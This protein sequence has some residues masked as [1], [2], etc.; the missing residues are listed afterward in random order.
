MAINQ[1]HKNKSIS[2]NEYIQGINTTQSSLTSD[3]GFFVP[4]ETNIC[5]LIDYNEITETMFEMDCY[6]NTY[7]KNNVF[8]NICSNIK[9]NLFI[10]SSFILYK[11]GSVCYNE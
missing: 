8:Y 4:L 6:T 7:I 1:I 10:V 5:N 11:V 2:F 3:W 9:S